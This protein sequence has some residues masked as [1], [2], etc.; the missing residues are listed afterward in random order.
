MG[1]ALIQ[2]SKKIGVVVLNNGWRSYLGLVVE[3]T[4]ILEFADMLPDA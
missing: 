1:D 4:A 3:V 2:N